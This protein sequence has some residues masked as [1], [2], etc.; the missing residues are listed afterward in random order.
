MI[1]A[2]I[3]AL[4]ALLLTL[5]ASALWF[6]LICASIVLLGLWE[7]ASLKKQSLSIF[8]LSSIPLVA[9][10]IYGREHPILLLLL[11]WLTSGVW[12]GLGIDLVYNN[13]ATFHSALNSFAM[14]VLLMSGAWSG[15]VLL[16]AWAEAGPLLVISVLLLVWAA[17]SF[18]YLVGKR[19]GNRKL[20][21][22]LSPGKSI[23]G[24]AGGVVGTLFIAL[25]AGI[26]VLRING[27]A[28]LLW[29]VLGFF[30]AIISV[31]GDLYESRL[32]RIAGVKDSGRMLPGHG[33]ILDRIDSMIAVLP[34]VAAGWS[35][36]R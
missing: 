26:A 19:F 8:L 7:W 4:A 25:I 29:M 33:G 6:D 36:A 34:M 20:A 22:T 24:V 10:F 13:L 15:L 1:T 35:L 31:V 17:D 16:H 32:K 12:I 21:P 14:G 3:L 2:A 11:C 27:E 18:A 28:L 9:L 23:E 5:S 30:A